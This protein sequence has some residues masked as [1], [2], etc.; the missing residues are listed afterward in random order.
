MLKKLLE[1]GYFFKELPPCFN[2]K[3]FSNK[4]EKLYDE[5]DY[6]KYKMSKCIKISYPKNNYG[7]RNLSIPN[8]L[9]YLK[10][11]KIISDNWIEIEKKLNSKV[12][13]SKIQADD[14]PRA[15]NRDDINI[16]DIK[17][18]G[19]ELS[20]DS[21]YEAKIDIAKFYDSIYTHIIPWCLESKEKIKFQ[22]K[23]K[24]SV[25]TKNSI[26][27][28]E[29]DKAIRNCQESQTIGIPTGPDISD[30][31]SE[32]I[33]CRVDEEIL[34][35]DKEIKYI[36]Y[37]DDIFIFDY[38]K[39][40]LLQKIRLFRKVL[41]KYELSLND[42][43][44]KIKEYPYR[45]Q[46]KWVNEILKKNLLILDEENIFEYFDFLGDQYKK[47]KDENIYV[48]GIQ[49]LTEI[50]NS[51]NNISKINNILVNILLKITLLVPKVIKEVIVIL[52]NYEVREDKNKIQDFFN[53]LIKENLELGHDFEVMWAIW[54]IEVLDLNISKENL[55]KILKEGDP[56]SCILSLNLYSKSKINF[57]K[58]DELKILKMRLENKNFF[59]EE[60]ILLYECIEK[61]W[62]SKEEIQTNDFLEKLLAN[63]ISFY[64]RNYE[65]KKEDIF[66]EGIGAWGVS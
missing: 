9:H 11:S 58:K 15:I 48:I 16:I 30:I 26:L 3:L 34:T 55:I 43:K 20:Y 44:T 33:L 40:K 54:G 63:K 21:L 64:N 35:E 25:K 32:L 19:L 66:Q 50:L 12:S 27:G 10:L 6:N 57:K 14:G 29:L 42:K 53:R 4:V 39:D 56:F 38:S 59:E 2:S 51:K 7:R 37:K 36:R 23:N 62:I 46:E 60:W 24:D 18:R 5:D 8:P 49:N 41:H 65:Y 47:E 31:I 61:N 28:D 1:K 13:I 52:K 17:K 22:L 45:L